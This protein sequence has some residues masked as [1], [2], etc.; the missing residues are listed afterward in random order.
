MVHTNLSC[1]TTRSPTPPQIAQFGSLVN[2][3]EASRADALVVS[4]ARFS[5][6]PHS[7]HSGSTL[8]N[9]DVAVHEPEIEEVAGVDAEHLAELGGHH[10]P[11]ELIDL[12]SR[13]DF[14]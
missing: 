4:L 10:D 6:S 3:S 11:A 1:R 12:S 14:P 9:R 2:L 13:A 5:R 8:I 7:A